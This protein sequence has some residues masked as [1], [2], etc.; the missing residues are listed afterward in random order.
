[1]KGMLSL[2]SCFR[3]E[4]L[5]YFF[6]LSTFREFSLSW[7][8]S[9]RRSSLKYLNGTYSSQSPSR[10]LWKSLP[11]WRMRTMSL[12]DDQPDDEKSE[13]YSDEDEADILHI[14]EVSMTMTMMIDDVIIMT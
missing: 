7:R 3:R 14:D 10:L 2:A 13:D 4:L 5:V 9:L 1:M 6:T 8:L 12:T 11:W